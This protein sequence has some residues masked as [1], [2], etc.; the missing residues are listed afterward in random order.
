MDVSTSAPMDVSALAPIDVSA[1]AP[2]DVTI[3]PHLD[4]VAYS[5]QRV[6]KVAIRKKLTPKKRTQE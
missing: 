1:S 2:M 4:V 6:H 3:S 5:P